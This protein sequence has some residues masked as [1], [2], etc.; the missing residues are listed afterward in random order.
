MF[1]GTVFLQLPY[2][3]R[4]YSSGQSRRRRNSTTSN[5]QGPFGG[6]ERVGY[7]WAYNTMLTKAWRTGALGDER[8]AERLLKDF[9]D[10]CSNRDNRLV[11]FWDS[12]QERMNASAP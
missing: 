12:C 10:F 4:K 5:S 8:M 7:Y 11:T 2:S 9:T 1:S 6:E 3:R